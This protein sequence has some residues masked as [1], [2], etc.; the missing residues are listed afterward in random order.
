MCCGDEGLQVEVAVGGLFC[1]LREWGS[2]IVAIFK[3]VIKKLFKLQPHLIQQPVA[4]QGE[5]DYG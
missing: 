1:S 2:S 3:S 5:Y 4:L